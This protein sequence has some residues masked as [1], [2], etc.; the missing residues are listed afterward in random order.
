MRDYSA[1]VSSLQLR[2]AGRSQNPTVTFLKTIIR[3]AS[4]IATP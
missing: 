3:A 1:T 2:P 4:T